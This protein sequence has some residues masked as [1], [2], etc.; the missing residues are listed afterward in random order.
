MAEPVTLGAAVLVEVL[1]A[2]RRVSHRR[3]VPIPDPSALRD[4]LRPDPGLE[5]ASARGDVHTGIVLVHD[6]VVLMTLTARRATPSRLTTAQPRPGRWS[7][8]EDDLSFY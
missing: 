4:A 1:F 2:L 3:D 8:E 5:L 6:N 7:P